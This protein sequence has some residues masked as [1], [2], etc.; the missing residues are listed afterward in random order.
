MKPIQD[1]SG[2]PN[3]LRKMWSAMSDLSEI[4]REQFR[5]LLQQGKTPDEAAQILLESRRTIHDACQRLVDEP[6]DVLQRLLDELDAEEATDDN[7]R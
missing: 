3:S 1:K 6:T 2:L 5:Q 7:K 4:D